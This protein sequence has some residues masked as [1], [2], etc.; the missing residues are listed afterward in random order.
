MS[1]SKRRKSEYDVDS[2]KIVTFCRKNVKYIS[3]GI[4]T[5]ALVVVLFMTVGDSKSGEDSTSLGTESSAS[6]EQGEEGDGGQ[7]QAE[8]QE[9]YDYEVDMPE[10]KELMSTYYNSYAA[11]DVDKLDSITESL[12]DMEKSYIKM[13]NDYVENYTNVVCYSQ[14]GKEDGTY[15]ASATFSMKFHGVE[16]GLPGMDFFYIQTNDQGK[17]Y[18]DSLY[19]PFNRQTEEQ[20]T[21]PEIEKLIEDFMENKDVSK[22]HQ[23]CQDEYDKAI[24]SNEDLGKMEVTM[25]SAIKD[26]K[27]AYD[28]D[29]QE[30]KEKQE[31]NKEKE[32]QE[33]EE[34]K[35]KKEKK[36][37]EE[38]QKKQEEAESQEPEAPAEDGN[39][40]APEENTEEN[41]GS[42]GL[43]YVPEG[44]VLTANDGYNVRVSMSESA[45]L[46]GT[47]GIGDSITIVLSYAEGWTKVEWNGQ[48][49]YIRT[50]L[51]LNN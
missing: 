44:T 3:A 29:A 35:K 50:D 43:N 24:A 2:N 13:M 34:K 18:I 28:P 15:L 11:G 14:K 6:G 42:S 26:W 23:D 49:G 27:D 45:E 22:L 16:D 1:N 51:L 12:S 36:I 21:D 19:C 41:T 10:I 40:A 8:E 31:E 32:E 7:Q 46:I 17:L 37:K 33:K 48:T 9:D 20:E 25:K 38:E 47:T 30:D 5:V 4:L 39:E